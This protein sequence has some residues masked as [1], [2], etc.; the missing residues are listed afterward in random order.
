MY[1]SFV[2]DRMTWGA[3]SAAMVTLRICVLGPF[4][5]LL[6]DHPV[7]H[8]ESNK[9]R[10][11]LTYLTVEPDRPYSREFLANLLWPDNTRTSALGNLRYT[12]SSLRKNLKDRRSAS[13][14]RKTPYLS[15]NREFL[16]FNKTSS[17]SVDVW[18][19]SEPSGRTSVPDSSYAGCLEQAISLYRGEFLE[20]FSLPDSAG[21]E[22]WLLLKREQYRRQMLKFL[23]QLAD[24]YMFIGDHEHAQIYAW[25]QVEMEPWL[26]EGYQQLMRALA[27][28]GHR[29][30]AL[31][32]FN[33]CRRLLKVELGIEPSHETVRIYESICNDTITD[34]LEIAGQHKVILS[35]S[36]KISPLQPI[37]VIH[38]P[39]LD[40]D[41]IPI[42][43]SPS[44][45]FGQVEVFPEFVPG[46]QDVEGYSH[47]ILLYSFKHPSRSKL[48]K[49]PWQD[50]Q[51]RSLAATH[52]PAGLNQ[53]G[54]SV[55]R[56]ESQ[57][58][59]I[60]EIRGV[61]VPD[62]TLLLDIKPSMLDIKP[63]PEEVFDW[64]K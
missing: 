49:K 38:S 26:E 56:L 50:D 25:K 16:Q 7:T 4:Q 39:Y 40:G 13:R 20:G 29:S 23:H 22:E 37:G 15:A 10:A 18:E 59:N 51:P 30:E 2:V 58:D 52:Q 1:N 45:T 28:G 24:Y 33:T 47:L 46:L 62:G 63:S 43:A 17:V 35:W 19:F 3:E 21:F 57:H 34:S 32:Q 55:V 41:R 53:L 12:I 9:V 42:Q 31:T 36:D 60:L 61:D 14:N 64:Y 44:T 6:N 11:L 27:L 8:F 48:Q 54:M 5:V